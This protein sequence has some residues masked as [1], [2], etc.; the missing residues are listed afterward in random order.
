MP[1]KE[2]VKVKLKIVAG[3]VMF[4]GLLTASPLF[5]ETAEE[6]VSACRLLENAK[7]VGDRV[8]MP[9]DFSSGMCWGAFSAVQSAILLKFSDETD[10]MLRVCAPANSTRTQLI[11]IFMAYIRTYPDKLHEDFMGMAIFAL[12]AAFPCSQKAKAVTSK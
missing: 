3:P 9:K 7:V 8:D 1:R 12:R 10:P 5:G 6:I 4:L 2:K 11:A